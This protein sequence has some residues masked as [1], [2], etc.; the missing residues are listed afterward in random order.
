LIISIEAFRE[1]E[2][3]AHIAHISPTPLL[4][5]VAQHDRLTLTDLALKA[6]AR[7]LEPKELNILKGG[8]FDGYSGPYFE[9]NAGR[10]VEFLKKTLCAS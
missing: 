3:A 2:P 5:T 8:H 4:M 7:A 9:G 1:Y 6:Y 10:Q